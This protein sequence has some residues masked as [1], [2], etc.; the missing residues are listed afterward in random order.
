MWSNICRI[1]TERRRGAAPLD[2]KR[3][4][5]TNTEKD[6][7]TEDSSRHNRN[8]RNTQTRQA[9]P[10]RR[11]QQGESAEGAAAKKG[12]IQKVAEHAKRSLIIH[13]RDFRVGGG[14]SANFDTASGAIEIDAR[15][16]AG[17]AKRAQRQTRAGGTARSRNDSE[18]TSANSKYA[19]RPSRK[20]AQQ[21]TRRK[22]SNENQ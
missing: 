20:A 5:E 9:T 18:R 8:R 6:R 7:H 19:S 11:F 12:K 2:R 1:K 22:R 21:P 13:K 16:P 4:E 10:A 15:E 17:S 14:G 3:R